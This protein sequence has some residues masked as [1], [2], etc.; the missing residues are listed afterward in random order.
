MSK[1]Y[2][3]IDLHS[4]NNYS[5]IINEKDEWVA[6]KRLDNNLK[7][8]DAFFRP[9]KDRLTA[10]AVESTYNGYWLVDGLMDK[11]YNIKLANPSQMDTFKG[12]KYQD[13]KTDTRWLA[14][15]IRLGILPESY[16]YP[17]E[18]RPLRDL[19]RKRMLLM[20]KRTGIL[21]SLNN[22]FATWLNRKIPRSELYFLTAEELE[23]MFKEQNLYQAARSLLNIVKAIE[24]EIKTIEAEAYQQMK[25]NATTKRLMDLPGIHKLLAMTID[26]ETGA[27]GRFKR[28]KNYIS[29]CGLVESKRISSGK[30]KGEANRKSRNATLRWAYGEAA[31][32]AVRCYEKIKRYK[33]RLQK[34]KKHATAMAIIA[35]KIARIAYKT[36]KDE[37]FVYKEELLFN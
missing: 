5:G 16:I 19:L 20:G 37:K 15:M 26:L 3:A 11:R 25:D 13:D 4:N 24:K 1:L 9:Y 22:Q 31:A 27:R 6:K 28:D 21:S 29:Y 34:R 30:K 8:I 2:G 35:S 14:T 10:I 23:E 12:L 36:M 33:K 17:R 18:I 7:I 32:H